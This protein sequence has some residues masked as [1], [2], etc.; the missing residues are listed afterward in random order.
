MLAALAKVLK[1]EPEVLGAAREVMAE[2]ALPEQLLYRQADR[3]WSRER[4]VDG[5]ARQEAWV[6]KTPACVRM[7]E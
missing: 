5:T 7:T 2:F 6:K 4:V 3:R 1:E